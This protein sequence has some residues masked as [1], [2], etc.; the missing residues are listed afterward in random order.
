M[1][2]IFLKSL[3]PLPCNLKWCDIMLVLGKGFFYPLTV[4]IFPSSHLRTQIV[5]IGMAYAKIRCMYPEI[6]F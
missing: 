2:I 6:K 1:N 4:P 3:T 5:P